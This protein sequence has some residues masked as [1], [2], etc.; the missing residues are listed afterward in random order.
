MLIN[1][2]PDCYK[3]IPDVV[4]KIKRKVQGAAALLLHQEEEETDKNQT[5]ANQTNARKAQN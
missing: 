4:K 2:L 1:D 3:L 5:S